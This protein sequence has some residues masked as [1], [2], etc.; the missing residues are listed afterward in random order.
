[1]ITKRQAIRG[2]LMALASI[3]LFS[4]FMFSMFSWPPSVMAATSQTS[5]TVSNV[6]VAVSIGFA[7][8]GNFSDG[9]LFGSVDQN[10]NDNNATKNYVGNNSA[11]CDSNADCTDYFVTMST[12]NNANADTCIRD[13]GNLTSG[14]NEITNTGYTYNATSV[15]TNTTTT[16]DDSIAITETS[17]ITGTIALAADANQT[18]RFWLDVPDNTAS[19]TYNN[20][21]EIKVLQTGVSC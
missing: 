10:T 13:N 4:A 15:F 11:D 1:M 2:G 20:T 5:S 21:V 18:F 14:S 6:T 12:D 9:I 17:V 19:G 8:S 3:I 16:A 7:F